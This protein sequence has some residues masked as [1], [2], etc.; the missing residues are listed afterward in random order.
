MSQ[1]GKGVS[2][3]PTPEK[4]TP[5]VLNLGPWSHSSL[6]LGHPFIPALNLTAYT[7]I[8][9]QNTVLVSSYGLCPY[10]LSLA[11]PTSDILPLSCK[12]L[13]TTHRFVIQNSEPANEKLPHLQ[14]CKFLHKVMKTELKIP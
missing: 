1:Q 2:V 3:L 8:L 4:K 11:L 10:F 13:R 6:M 14:A 9:D 12:D 7:V 5:P